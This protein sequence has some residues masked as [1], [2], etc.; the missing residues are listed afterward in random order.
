MYLQQQ[1]WAESTFFNSLGNDHAEIRNRLGIFLALQ[2]RL[3]RKDLRTSP[4]GTGKLL[5]LKIQ[6]G[7]CHAQDTGHQKE[8]QNQLSSY[9]LPMGFFRTLNGAMLNT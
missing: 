2:T 3:A 4:C 8:L 7:R 6:G 9:L 5:C 1:K